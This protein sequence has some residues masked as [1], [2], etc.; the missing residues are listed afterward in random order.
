MSIEIEYTPAIYCSMRTDDV[1]TLFDFTLCYFY[2]NLIYVFN[3]L[4][5]EADLSIE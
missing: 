1:C 3:K 5:F 4:V 2:D